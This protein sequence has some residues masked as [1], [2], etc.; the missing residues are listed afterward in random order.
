MPDV[1]IAIT[2]F[3]V[4]YLLIATERIPK[5]AATL[6]GAAIML[7]LSVV[8]LRERLRG[9]EVTQGHQADEV[10]AGGQNPV[11]TRPRPS[12]T[13]PHYERPRPVAVR[14]ARQPTEPSGCH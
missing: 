13:V 6:D 2:A 12:R 4:A 1:T 10:E 3:V 5:T 14:H 11:P 9:M 7:G 8:G